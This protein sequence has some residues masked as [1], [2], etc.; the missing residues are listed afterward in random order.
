MYCPCA[1]QCKKSFPLLRKFQTEAQVEKRSLDGNSEFRAR[2]FSPLSFFPI[3]LHFVSPRSI[4]LTTIKFKQYT[5]RKERDVNHIVPSCSLANFSK[6]STHSFISSVVCFKD[7]HVAS[8]HILL[9]FN[10]IRMSFAR[11][12]HFVSDLHHSYSFQ[13]KRSRL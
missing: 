9:D 7:P 13:E 10:F 6:H 1:D 5:R 2:L 4:L 3:T 12:A 8:Q 11:S